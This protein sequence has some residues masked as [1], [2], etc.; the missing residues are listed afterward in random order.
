LQQ[1]TARRIDGQ[2]PSN[3]TT[4]E[5]AIMQIE[6]KIRSPDADG[7]IKQKII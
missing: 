2:N 6:D 3:S 1:E 5:A 4:M 7:G